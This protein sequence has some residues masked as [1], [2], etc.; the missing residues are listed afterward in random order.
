MFVYIS[1]FI[2]YIYGEVIYFTGKW[3][4]NILDP[5]KKKK[6]KNE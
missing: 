6:K 5:K 1:T 4:Q 3:V 2:E